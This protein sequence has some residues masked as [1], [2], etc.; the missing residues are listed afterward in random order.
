M[1]DIKIDDDSFSTEKTE[2]VTTS[3]TYSLSF[4][5]AQKQ[6]IL[7]LKADQIAQRDA[8]L[9]EVNALIAKA[10][11]VGVKDPVVTTV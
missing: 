9:A 1:A 7:K 6:A 2:T 5:K 10:K 4:L 3:L 8:E 11:A